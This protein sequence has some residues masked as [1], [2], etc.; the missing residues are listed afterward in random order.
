MVV[1]ME[2][3]AGRVSISLPSRLTF[4]LFNHLASM[5]AGVSLVRSQESTISWRPSAKR[6]YTLTEY[7]LANS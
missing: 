7:W 4:L 2:F 6:G 3:P 1:L 5:F